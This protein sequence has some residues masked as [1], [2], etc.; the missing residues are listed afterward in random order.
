MWYVSGWE[1]SGLIG[2]ILGGDV[3]GPVR[4]GV[5]GVPPSVLALLTVLFTDR[6][7]ENGPVGGR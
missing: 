7:V 4:I 2:G 6:D 5:L 1:S 3:K